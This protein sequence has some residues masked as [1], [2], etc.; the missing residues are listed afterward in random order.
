[1]FAEAVPDTT[2]YMI[3]GYA[4]FFSVLLIY[5]LS[6][7]LRWRKLVRDFHSLEELEG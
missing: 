5:L 3:T 4:V 6:L 2:G 1:M 7:A